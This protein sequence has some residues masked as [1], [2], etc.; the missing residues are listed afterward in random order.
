[1]NQ[2]VFVPERS[3]DDDILEVSQSIP[4]PTTSR[5]PIT[6][7][8]VTPVVIETLQQNGVNYVEDLLKLTQF[9]LTKMEGLGGTRIRQLMMVLEDYNVHL[10][11]HPDNMP[12]PTML[13]EPDKHG[14]FLC[15]ECNRP[16]Q[17]KVSLASHRHFTHQVEGTHPASV[18]GKNE[19]AAGKQN[20]SN[21]RGLTYHGQWEQ[22]GDKFYCL[23]CNN[24]RAY[25]S[26]DSITGH[27]YY[28]H[29]GGKELLRGSRETGK[30]VCDQCGMR[31]ATAR[32]VLNHGIKSHNMG[33]RKQQ[34][35]RNNGINGFTRVEIEQPT[36][37]PIDNTENEYR[38]FSI[39]YALGHIQA[40]IDQHCA[41]TGGRIS[42]VEL[43]RRVGTILASS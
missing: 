32:G 25:N 19:R 28:N 16:F 41:K 43:A 22:R 36:S 10:K 13:V 27:I 2:P 7:L 20:H 1:M 12:M 29:K 31:F 21:M 11:T 15:P 9:D 18:R 35:R 30:F 3:G 5:T 6:Q 34:K 40:W 23:V 8:R 26:R 14:N 33:V 17:T 38:E 37:A 4:K 24:G 42:P 39:G